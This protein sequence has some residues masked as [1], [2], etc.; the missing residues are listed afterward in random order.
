MAL[1][2]DDDSFAGKLRLPLPPTF[3]GK[4]YEWEEW[5]W[6][7]KA[8]LSIFDAQVA[9]FLE[10]HEADPLEISDE[11]LNVSV[12]D[13]QGVI[14]VDRAAARSCVTFS[15]KLHYLFVNLIT[16]AARLVI[17]QNYE[18]NDFETWRRLAKKFGFPDRIRYGPLLIQFL[19]FK[20]NFQTFE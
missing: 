8:Y 15:R 20:F 18:S 14:S 12:I 3:S 1:A 17:R 4:S 7:F 2:S 10:A 19:D 9:A 16:D 13:D 6:I 11:D 5:S